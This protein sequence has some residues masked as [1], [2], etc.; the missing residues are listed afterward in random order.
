MKVRFYIEKRKDEEGMLLTKERPVFMTVSFHGKRAII[1]SG[2]KI[3]LQWWDPNLQRVKSEHVDSLA[4]NMLIESLKESA[5]ASWKAL[6]SLSEYPGVAEFRK[7]FAELRPRISKGFFDL[8]YLFMSEKS[9][10]WSPSTYRKVRTIY[11]HLREFENQKNYPLSFD[12]INKDFL[13]KFADYYKE[14]GNS[15][16]TTLKAINILIWFMN[17]ATEKGYN[18]F[19]DYRSFYKILGKVKSESSLRISLNWDELMRMY[20]FDTEDRKLI[21]VNDMFCFMCFTGLRFSELKNLKKHDIGEEAI[22]INTYHKKSRQV[23][24]NKH[25]KEIIRKYENRYFRGD[26]AF[27]QISLMTFNK[28]LRILAKRVEIN[29]TVSPFGK[30]EDRMMKYE[31]MTAGVAVNTFIAN[32]IKLEIPS[33]LVSVFTGVKQ[34]SRYGTL[35]MELA[36]MQIHKFDNKNLAS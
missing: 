28:Y 7:M 27:P 15:H 24:F 8:F 19:R 18:V 13:D 9:S 17:W 33:D 6:V 10:R 20:A 21:R 11:S 2:V 16:H 34:D 14:K 22:I 3:D 23:P 30:Q 36:K 26:F 5:N 29:A 35:Q 12:R 25:A 31:L 1:A 4:I 32:A